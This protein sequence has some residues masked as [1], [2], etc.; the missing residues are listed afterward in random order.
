MNFNA[1]LFL[2]CGAL[3][4][5]ISVALGAAGAHAL[6]SLPELTQSTFRTA[7]QYPQLH[8]LGLLAVGLIADRIASRWI[9]A[10]GWLLIAGTLLFSGNLY[11]RTL[12]GIDAFRIAVPWGGGAWILGWLAL[13]VGVSMASRKRWI[14]VPPA[15]TFGADSRAP[16]TR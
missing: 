11:L 7:L 12:A 9:L 3:S 5:A 1:K 16:S 14:A 4:A 8:A 15:P 2:A 6:A 10:A 13:A